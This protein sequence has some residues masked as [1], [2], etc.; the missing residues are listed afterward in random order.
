[1]DLAPDLVLLEV[2]SFVSVE[3]RFGKLR[4][5]CRRWKQVVEF[6][7]QKDLVVYGGEF[8][9]K[10][11]WPSDYRQT[12]HLNTA[13]KPFF[14]F[15]LINDHYK[16]IKR[17]FLC[18]I[19][20]VG[21]ERKG[22]LAKLLECM[23]QVEELSIDQR[24]VEL[25]PVVKEDRVRENWSFNLDGW[26]FPNLKVLNVIQRFEAKASINAPRLEKLILRDFYFTRGNQSKGPMIALSHPERL[27]SLQC[28]LIDKETAVF[29]NLLHLSAE[30]VKLDFHLSHHRNLKWLNLCVSFCDYLNLNDRFDFHK[31]IEGLIEQRRELKLDDL[32]ITNFGTKCEVASTW[33]KVENLNSVFKI[34]PDDLSRLKKH[35]TIDYLPWETMLFIWFMPN[36]N[37]EGLGKFCRSRLNIEFV[38]VRKVLEDQKMDPNLLIKFLVEIG[39]VKYLVI[40]K[41]IGFTCPFDQRFYDQLT[42]VPYIG[43]LKIR[44]TS[45]VTDF[46]F[47]CRI[48]FLNGIGL[49]LESHAIDSFYEA[50][51]R[52]KIRMLH[53]I[54]RFSI[55]EFRNN[56]ITIWSGLQKKDE[57]DNLDDAF[58]T[59]K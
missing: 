2:F 6:K 47:I 56:R 8:P 36:L 19:N 52:S 18:G 29:S 5:V 54:C 57:F 9:F 44:G 55:L 49:R 39:G 13:A 32:E 25:S 11:R 14:D 53:C 3:E 24:N 31:T 17:L 23:C 40:D 22:L 20:L 10:N 15:Y 27:K 12:D 34:Y 46:E 41:C 58:A 7:I 26:T 4:L 38:N 50:F 28:P 59:L 1:M 33:Y 35:F 48:R 16:A 43:A 21:L 45:L 37:R 42:K 51:K 30:H